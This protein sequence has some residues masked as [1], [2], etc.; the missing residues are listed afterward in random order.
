MAESLSYFQLI[1]ILGKG[2]KKKV[3]SERDY[4]FLYII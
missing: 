2:N 4:L 1:N 3:T